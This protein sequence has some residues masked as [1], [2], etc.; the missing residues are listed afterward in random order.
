MTEASPYPLGASNQ[1]QAIET[2]NELNQQVP[3]PIP[4][5]NNSSKE[6]TESPKSLD[7]SLS[8]LLTSSPESESKDSVIENEQDLIEKLPETK[9]QNSEKETSTESKDDWGDVGW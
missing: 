9:G 5:I 2:Q 1:S 7:A 3:Q 6:N 4:E 8:S